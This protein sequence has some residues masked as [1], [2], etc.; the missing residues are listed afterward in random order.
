MG[1][2]CGIYPQLNKKA[3]GDST[4]LVINKF[5]EPIVIGYGTFVQNPEQAAQINEKLKNN[6]WIKHENVW[7]R[8]KLFPCCGEDVKFIDKLTKKTFCKEQYLETILSVI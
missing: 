5:K 8:T 2:S 6:L 7:Y 4:M 1:T 3:K